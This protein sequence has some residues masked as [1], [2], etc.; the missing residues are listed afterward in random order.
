MNTKTRNA[1]EAYFHH[2]H[3]NPP[4]PFNPEFDP[5]AAPRSTRAARTMQ[6]DGFYDT[7]TREECALEHRRRV[8]QYKREQS[9]D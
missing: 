6:E 3:G 4:A 7:H 5:L 1:L 8:E 9:H 2:A